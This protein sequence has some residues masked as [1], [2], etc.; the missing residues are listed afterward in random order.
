MNL[1]SHELSQTLSTIESIK[2]Y[3]TGLVASAFD[4]AHEKPVRLTYIGGEFAKSVHMPFEKYV[5]TLAEREQIT[6]P[7]M[8]RKL[9]PFVANYC[10]DVL[11]LTRDDGG[12][13]FVSPLASN[14][15][16]KSQVSVVQTPAQLRFHRA[17]WA[18]FIRPLEG[19]RFLNL[20][21]IGFT[22]SATEPQDG[23]WREIESRFILG[24]APN[25]PVDG[26]LLQKR[27]EEWALHAEIPISRLAVE[28]KFPNEQSRSL[29]QLFA[30]IDSLPTPLAATWS[31]PAAVLKHLRNAR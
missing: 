10:N 12:V 6:V 18:A 15:V 8:R 13:Y 9:A 4:A 17:V 27:I 25:A 30:I 20:D 1:P 19:R 21:K 23:D 11:R 24:L 2:I 7:I 3:L 28:A 22:D 5:T 26:T 29:E 16:D 14:E 31:I